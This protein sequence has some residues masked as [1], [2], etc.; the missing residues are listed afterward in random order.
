MPAIPTNYH[1]RLKAVRIGPN[2]QA[3]GDIAISGN[4]IMRLVLTDLIW[5]EQPL[6]GHL[7]LRSSD[8]AIQT[9]RSG[10]LV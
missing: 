9:A 5:N 8:G 3:T 6:K 1:E 10:V 2:L 7:A 4:A